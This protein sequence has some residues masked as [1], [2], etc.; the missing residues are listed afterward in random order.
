[1]VKTCK[2]YFCSPEKRPQNEICCNCIKY[3]N[4]KPCL[5][6]CDYVYFGQHGPAVF[7]EPGQE[8]VK[9]YIWIRSESQDVEENF[10]LWQQRHPEIDDVTVYDH[11]N[12]FLE[13]PLFE[14]WSS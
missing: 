2:C 13:S 8:D 10:K 14:K 5:N 3:S 11:Q 12:V 7:Y 1:M 9:H 6:C 4:G